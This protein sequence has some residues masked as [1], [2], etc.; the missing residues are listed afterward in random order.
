MRDAVETQSKPDFWYALPRGYLDMDVQPSPEGLQ[1]VARQINELPPDETRSRA[2]ELF[3]L[4]AGV[5]L[6]LQGQHVRGCALGMHPDDHGGAALSVLT[7]SSS[8]MPGVNPKLV[9]TKMMA[10]GTGTSPDEDI[11]PVNLPAGA[12]FLTESIRKTAAP[13][14]APG[15]QGSPETLTWQGTV[16][17]PDTGSSSVIALQLVTASVELADDYRS[18]LLCTART[19]TF[20][21]PAP[22]EKEQ[23]SD[24]AASGSSAQ[25]IRS[26]F[27]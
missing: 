3:R 19:I 23:G 14:A 1:D 10:G 12:G 15:G 24:P 16:A 17:I 11:R 26:V 2:Y 27:G 9:L 20:N 21:D 13:A 18:V 5:V 22:P 7:V 4:Y 6:M 25:A 8:P